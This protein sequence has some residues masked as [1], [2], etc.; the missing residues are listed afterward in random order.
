MSVDRLG[1]AE[2]VDPYWFDSLSNLSGDRVQIQ[3]AN[4]ER[5]P[6]L[7][8]DYP[9]KNQTKISGEFKYQMPSND[10]YSP[11]GK[12]EYRTVSGLFILSIKTDWPREEE[13]ISDINRQISNQAEIHDSFSINRTSLWQ[14]LDQAH[15][16]SELRIVGPNGTYDAAD[17]LS[18]LRAPG[19]PLENLHEAHD[20]GEIDDYDILLTIIK[21]LGDVSSINSLSDLPIDIYDLVVDFVEADFIYDGDFVSIVYDRG[22][23]RLDAMTNDARE[24]M[25]Q[26][27]EKEIVSDP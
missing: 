9:Y 6:Q 7:V 20:A 10:Q 1:R 4:R 17:L 22:R 21:Q 8:E 11:G 2:H 5:V 24:Y 23:M 15:S 13:V 14:L 16:I 18:V 27:L 3:S 26:L 25:L 19:D 12:Y